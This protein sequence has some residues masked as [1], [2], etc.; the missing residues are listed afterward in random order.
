MGQC[1]GCIHGPWKLAA[2]TRN[3]WGRQG[4]GPAFC[5]TLP[6]DPASRRRPCA[7]TIRLDKGLPPP[8]CRSCSAHQQKPRRGG[9]KK[10]AVMVPKTQRRSRGTLHDP[11]RRFNPV[12]TKNTPA[13]GKPARARSLDRHC[14]GAVTLRPRFLPIGEC[15][16]ERCPPPARRDGGRRTG[17][18]FSVVI[19]GESVRSSQCA[20]S[21]PSPSPARST[22]NCDFLTVHLPDNADP[23][24]FEHQEW[25]SRLDI[26]ILADGGSQSVQGEYI[27]GDLF[28]D[29]RLLSSS[30]IVFEFGK[31]NDRIHFAVS[32]QIGSANIG[33]FMREYLSRLPRLCLG[34]KISE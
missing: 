20:G 28:I 2:W 29:A 24:S 17:P 10:C 31:N 5:S 18:P 27:K 7:S 21:I 30:R 14:I 3:G 19:V 23:T 32:D 13:G 16:S 11:P 22:E 9:A 26:R 4:V 1:V 33:A 15:P 8:S 34:S 25:V 12:A 6:S